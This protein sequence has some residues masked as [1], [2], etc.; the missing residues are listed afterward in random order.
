MRRV[1]Y[2][3]IEFNSIDL[4]YQIFSENIWVIDKQRVSLQC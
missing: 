3:Y 2:R 4:I 1:F